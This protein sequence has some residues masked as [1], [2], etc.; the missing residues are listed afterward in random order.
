MTMVN[1][2]IALVLGYLLGSIP[3]AYL[4][5]RISAGKDIRR[6]GGGNVGGYNTFREVGTVPALL[7]G[8]VDVGKGAVAVAVAYWLL[9]V[10]PLF[11]MLAGFAAVVGHNWMLFLRFSGGKGMAAV[12]GALAVLLPAYGYWLGLVIVLGVILVGMIITRNVTLSL[13][14]GMVALLFITIFMIGSLQAMFMTVAV[15]VLVGLRFLPT[16]RAAW[17]KAGGIKSFVFTEIRGRK[18]GD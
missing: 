7:V 6:L 10:S 17:I 16:A 14:L 13:A 9:D 8:I 2:I 4:A 1:E 5:T 18:P 15:G 3:A 12:I 11:V